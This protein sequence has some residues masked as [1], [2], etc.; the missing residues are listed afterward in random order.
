MTTLERERQ[1]WQQQLKGRDDLLKGSQEKLDSISRQLKTREAAAATLKEHVVSLEL[2][3]EDK[4]ASLCNARTEALAER[5]AR[6]AAEE[7][8]QKLGLAQASL[9]KERLKYKELE[10]Q[11]QSHVASLTSLFRKMDPKGASRS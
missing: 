7:R 11:M 9:E 3:L 10:Q 2:Q 4:K 5:E 1:T 6:M 8:A